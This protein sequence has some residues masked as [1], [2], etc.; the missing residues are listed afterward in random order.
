MNTVCPQGFIKMTKMNIV[1]NY[2]L[3]TRFVAVDFGQVT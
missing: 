3:E 2:I 1:I